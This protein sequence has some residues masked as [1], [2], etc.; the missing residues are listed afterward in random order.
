M[1][2]IISIAIIGFIA[3]FVYQSKF[4][5]Y[6]PVQVQN[7]NSQARGDLKRA[8]F[9]QI[10]CCGTFN[11]YTKDV[12]VLFQ[13]GWGP[14]ATWET[15]PDVVLSVADV[16]GGYA[17]DI[18]YFFVLEAYHKKGNR[19]YQLIYCKDT[20]VRIT[21]QEIEFNDDEVPVKLGEIRTIYDGL[22][23][24][25]QRYFQSFTKDSQNENREQ[26]KKL[27]EIQ[28]EREKKWREQQ[29][30]IDKKHWEKTSEQF[31]KLN[32]QRQMSEKL[33][34]SNEKHKARWGKNP[35]QLREELQSK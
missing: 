23:R 16:N 24:D 9:S 32:D 11:N 15:Y 18:D 8:Y 2:K 31:K 33:K 34:E 3:Y 12:N 10:I 21:E 6:N 19:L 28:R 27:L 7:N 30:E 20:K 1:K 4:A 14:G 25:G 22:L 17:S 5:N 13:H 26:R 29:I 35:K